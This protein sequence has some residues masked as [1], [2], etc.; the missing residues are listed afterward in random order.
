[1]DHN[2]FPR[3]WRERWLEYFK[4]MNEYQREGKNKHD[5]A[6]DATTDIAEKIDGGSTYSF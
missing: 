6:P 5:D 4:A 3:N 2:Y 1:M